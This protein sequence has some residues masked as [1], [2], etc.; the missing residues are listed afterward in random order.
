MMASANTVWLRPAGAGCGRCE[1]DEAGA[2][3]SA[4]YGPPCASPDLAGD[5]ALIARVLQALRGVADSDG[6]LVD[7]QR[8]SAL[9]LRDGEAELTLTFARG[10]GPARLLAEEAFQCLRRELP[11]TDVYVT[12]AR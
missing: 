8:F 11:D 2:G 1:P 12:H 3:C 4:A 5:P 9:R 7:A 10:C 6:N